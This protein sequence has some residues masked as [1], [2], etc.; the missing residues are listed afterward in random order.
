[1]A[2]PADAWLLSA[3]LSLLSAAIVPGGVLMR[4]LGLT[5]ITGRGNRVSRVMSVFRAL[6]AW[7]PV[8]SLWGVLGLSAWLGDDLTGHP[9]SYVILLAVTTL[10]VSGAVQTI[11]K[12]SAG[13]HDR[14]CGTTLV[15]R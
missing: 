1:M 2:I 8:L 14:L 5:V 11:R 10:M 7:T 3:I 9:T 4:W 12:P 15:P 13:W 6:V